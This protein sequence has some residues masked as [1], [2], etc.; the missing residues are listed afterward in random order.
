MA[1]DVN[2][3]GRGP[4]AEGGKQESDAALKARLAKLSHELEARQ[5]E[6]EHKAA[7]V[8]GSSLGAATSLGLQALI[9]FVTAVVVAPIIGWE[10]DAWLK[11]KPIFFIIFL[12]LGMAA[13]LLNVYRLAARPPRRERDSH[14]DRGRDPGING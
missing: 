2:E 8:P 7:E 13:G 5:G 6:S 3:S 9:E 11:T 4:Q 1:Q 14:E 12:F 10:I